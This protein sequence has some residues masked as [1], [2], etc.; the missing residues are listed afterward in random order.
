M[1]GVATDGR[2]LLRLQEAVKLQGKAAD[3]QMNTVTLIEVHV[4]T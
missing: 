3:K 4:L 2:R 1:A